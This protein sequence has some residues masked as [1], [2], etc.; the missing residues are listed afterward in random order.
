MPAPDIHILSVLSILALHIST[1]T[2][3]SQM[4]KKELDVKNNGANTNG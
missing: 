4:G 3:R 2:D 1:V